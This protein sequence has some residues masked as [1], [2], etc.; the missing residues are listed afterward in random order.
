MRRF[1]LAAAL[2]LLGAACRPAITLTPTPTPSAT[3]PALPPFPTYIGP[4]IRATLPPSWTPTFTPTASDTWTPTPITPTATLT[5]VPQLTDLCASLVVQPEFVQGHT[6]QWNDTITL[7]YGSPLTSVSA[8]DQG[9]PVPIRVRFLALH[10]QSGENLGV[11]LDGGQ[12]FAMQL[13]VNR[14][15][16]PGYYRWTVTIYG[17]GI[18]DR[19]PHTGSFFVAAP[20]ATAEA[21]AE[22]T[23]E[24]TVAATAAVT[25]AP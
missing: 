21:T 23:A 10:V 24:A 20:P 14:L 16:H 18:G 15:P 4:L 19:C 6:F 2:I 25:A 13:P 9:T 17:D 3:T 22:I 11:Q 1:I 5:P 8:S 7:I 12:T